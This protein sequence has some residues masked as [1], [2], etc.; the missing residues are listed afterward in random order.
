[1]SAVSEKQMEEKKV[2]VNKKNKLKKKVAKKL[3]K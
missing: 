2:Q 3:Q 1:M